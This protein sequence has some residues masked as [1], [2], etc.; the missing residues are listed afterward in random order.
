MNIYP[1]LYALLESN[2]NARRLYASAPPQV[3]CQLR[4][5]QGQIRSIAAL[6]AAICSFR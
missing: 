5:R 1:N 3:R 4:I 2:A 6:D